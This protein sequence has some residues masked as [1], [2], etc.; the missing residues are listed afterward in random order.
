MALVEERGEREKRSADGYS[1]KRLNSVKIFHH[2]RFGFGYS[3][4]I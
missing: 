2:A 3:I 1:V 4:L